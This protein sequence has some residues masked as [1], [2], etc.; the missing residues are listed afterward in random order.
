MGDTRIDNSKPYVPPECDEETGVCGAVKKD[1]PQVSKADPQVS[2]P[3]DDWYSPVLPQEKPAQVAQIAKNMG[4]GDT[5]S[6]AHVGLTKNHDGVEAEVALHKTDNFVFFDAGVQASADQVGPHATVVHGKLEGTI[7]GV[8]V[9]LSG[10]AGAVEYGPGIHNADGSTGIHVGGNATTIGGEVTVH[11]QGVG[12][13]TVGVGG[14]LSAEASVGAKKE[15][16]VTEV[17][18][19]ASWAFFTVGACFPVWTGRN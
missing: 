12:S 5:Q 4:A 9:S 17:C 1:E 16:N 11:K 13:L 8:D 19:R 2:H 7:A 14:G 15:G 6:V 10:D 18:G 3:G